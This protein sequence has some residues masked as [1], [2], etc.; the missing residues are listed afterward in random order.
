[1]TAPLILASASPARAAMLAA[2]GVVFEAVPAA[3]DEVAAREALLADGATPVDVAAALAELKARRAA[4]RSEGI[5]VGA[6]Q[7]LVCDGRL[8]AK[9][10]DRA[11][12]AVQLRALRGRTHRL[13]SAAVAFERGSPVW[14]HVGEARLTVRDFSDEF[15]EAYLDAE[16]DAVLGC[17]GAYRVEGRGAQLFTRI[18]GDHFVILGLPLLEL[19]G[20]LRSRGVCLP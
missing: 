3:V 9:P 14:R 5:V 2:V 7:V 11:G 17:V 10:G 4:W 13:L 8:H 16:G 18:E 20:F 12:A 15:L 6:D 1:M 19:L